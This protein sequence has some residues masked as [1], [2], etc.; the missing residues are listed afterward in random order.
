MELHLRNKILSDDW[1]CIAWCEEGVLIVSPNRHFA[2]LLI[3]N[4]NVWFGIAEATDD[5]KIIFTC[6]RMEEE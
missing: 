5:D 1:K 3:D 4:R 2:D 6:K